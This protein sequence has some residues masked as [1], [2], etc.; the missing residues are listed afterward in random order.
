MTSRTLTVYLRAHCH[1]CEQMVG[2][3]APWCEAHDLALQGVDVDEDPVL[4]ARFGE[5]V[6][7][8]CDGE[9]EL[10]RYVLDEAA[11]TKHLGVEQH[12]DSLR[13]ASTY[14]RIYA[15]A[16]LVPAGKVATYGQLATME[17]RASARQVGYAMA[18]LTD[19]NDVP[20]QRIINSKGEVSERSGG[21]GTWRQRDRL[22]HEGVLFDASGRVDFER[23]G[24]D[25][26]EPEWL[27][28][29]GFFTAP[30]PGRRSSSGGDRQRRSL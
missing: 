30:R 27:A 18:A 1:L 13:E 28:H 10:C 14:E 26:P 11:L 9:L 24:W 5:H 21:G 23:A 15:L 25:G 4:A 16:R 17:G 29:N 6:P 7:V 8:L 20:W 2:A 19:G 3:L 22:E 12:A